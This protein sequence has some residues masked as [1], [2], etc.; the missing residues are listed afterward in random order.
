MITRA[1][2]LGVVVVTLVCL[3]LQ[4][5]LFGVAVTEAIVVAVGTAVLWIVLV[6]LIRRRRKQAHAVKSF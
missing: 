1:D 2:F 6:V 4:H 3:V 5:V